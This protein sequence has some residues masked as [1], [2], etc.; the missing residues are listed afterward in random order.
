MLTAGGGRVRAAMLRS[1]P[2]GVDGGGLGHRT[3]GEAVFSILAPVVRPDDWCLG[4][5]FQGGIE[6]VVLEIASRARERTIIIIVVKVIIVGL[7][8]TFPRIGAY[9]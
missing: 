4:R 9:G 1:G 5:I 7:V 6:A 2:S 8:A 3:I